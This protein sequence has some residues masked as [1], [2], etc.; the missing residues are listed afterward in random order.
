MC[1][2]KCNKSMPKLFV[3]TGKMPGCGCVLEL[4]AS[5]YSQD[6]NM[7]KTQVNVTNMCGL[8]HHTVPPSLELQLSM[9]AL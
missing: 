8:Y 6:S 7:S 1:L 2:H 4:F 9:P 5:Q 3:K